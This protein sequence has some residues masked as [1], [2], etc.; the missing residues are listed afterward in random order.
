MT[1]IAL[2]DL[3]ALLGDTF[4]YGEAKRAG[5]GDK[6]LYRLRDS[7]ELTAVGGGVYRWADAP[8]ADID[9]IEIAERVPRA[10]LC[11]ETALAR[12]G[13]IDAIPAAIDIAIPR[14]SRRPSLRAPCRLHQFDPGTFDLGRRTADV[15]ARRPHRPLLA[16]AL[17]DRRHPSAPPR[18][19]RH[20]LGGAAPLAGRTRP[21]PGPA[22]R[23][24]PEL[25]RSRAGAAPGARG[26]AVSAPSRATPAGRAY[27]D[28]RNKARHDHRPVDE[29]LQLYVL[30]GFLARL[31]ASGRADQFVLKGGVPGSTRKRIARKRSSRPRSQWPAASP[32][33][34]SSLSREFPCWSRP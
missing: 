27:L 31:A 32:M 9:L 10:T 29:L 25:H 19:Q 26:S 20:G 18:G 13:L 3:R 4:T 28:L 21:K 8:P 16:G 33:V 14:G 6:R 12:H 1:A 7:G 17:A 34:K 24:C 23:A 22:H 11:L 5:I 30:E 15:G 2:S